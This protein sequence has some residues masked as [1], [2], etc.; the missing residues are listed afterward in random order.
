M[1]AA[2]TH[3]DPAEFGISMSDKAI[4]E[5]LITRAP[6]KILL[7]ILALGLT[8]AMLVHWNAR[9]SLQSELDAYRVGSAQKTKLTAAHVQSA[10]NEIYNSLRTIARLPGV[11]QIDIKKDVSQMDHDGVLLENNARLT[12]QEIYNALVADVAVSELYIVPVNFDP[13][14]TDLSRTLPHEPL[15]T[16]DKFILGKAGGGNP[17]NPDEAEAEE[18]EEIEIFEYRLMRTQLDWLL[19]NYPSEDHI[20]GLSYPQLSGPPVV[21]CDNTHFN[22]LKPD[23]RDREGLVMSVPFFDDEGNL[24][25]CIS[26][27]ILT[28]ELSNLLMTGNYAI[29][30]LSHQYIVPPPSQGQWEQSQTIGLG[31]DPDNNLLYS[32][33]YPIPTADQNGAWVLWAGNP[34]ESYWSRSGVRAAFKIRNLGYVAVLSLMLGTA[35]CVLVFMSINQRLIKLNAHLDQ[36][37]AERTTELLISR[38]AAV[39]AMEREQVAAIELINQKFA[40]DEHAIVSIADVK[41]NITYVNQNFCEISGYS[42]EELIGQNH[43]M[44][45]SVEHNAAIY[46]HLWK[47]ISRKQV[48]NGDIKNRAK[49]GIYY[50]VNMTIVPFKDSDEKITQYVAIRTDITSQKQSELKLVDINHRLERQTELAQQAAA[51][52]IAASKAKSEFLANMSHEIRTPMTAILGYTDLLMEMSKASIAQ[53]E[54]SSVV[55]TIRRNGEHLLQI[56][57]DILDISKIEADKLEAEHISFSP[58]ELISDVKTL[59]Q[60]RA[61]AKN[62]P[63]SIEYDGAIPET[64]KSDPTRIKQILVNLVGNAIKFTETGSIKI[65]VRLNKGNAQP[66][67]QFDIIDSGIGMS[68]EQ[69]SKLFRAF[70]QA[71]SSTTRKFGGTGLGL[72]ISKRLAELLGGS[73]T[74][75]STPGK[76]SRFR[77]T[78][79]TGSLEGVKMLENTSST[80]CSVATSAG[81][82]NNEIAKLDCRILLAE[83]GLDNQR[84]L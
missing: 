7:V 18:I 24:A 36:S 26:A 32:E 67:M 58:V 42:R 84:N 21:T 11:R 64:I 73:V 49:D 55:T 27:I 46:R 10:F 72:M 43:R 2:N 39:E 15:V 30:N 62:L 80:T 50:W 35:I 17:A 82:A 6:R 33:V 8:M 5:K 19:A 48:W 53:D 9:I 75:K 60:V 71:D 20:D 31:M 54:M 57:N 13:D 4:K 78:V 65:L 79:S 22:P 37:V 69:V 77:V 56:I 41:G 29:L 83:D 34:D 23:D 68:K 70:A 40:L 66:R 63:I 44:I 3:S 51:E 38:D 59:M 74:A 45:K 76:G 47:T 25:G 61:D 81:T 52:A 16:F 1:A 14:G 12:I 28:H